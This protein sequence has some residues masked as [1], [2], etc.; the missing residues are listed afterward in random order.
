MSRGI[1][2][3]M[4]KLLK[5]VELNLAYA[6]IIKLTIEQTERKHIIWEIDAQFNKTLNKPLNLTNQ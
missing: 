6:H 3:S 2:N 4:L 1:H 5:F